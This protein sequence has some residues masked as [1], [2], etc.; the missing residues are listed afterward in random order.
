MSLIWAMQ[1]GPHRMRA[2]REETPAFPLVLGAFLSVMRGALGGSAWVQASMGV[3]RSVPKR[4][5]VGEC[6][7]RLDVTL[8]SP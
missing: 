7:G 6:G 1:R 4:S 3:Q 5:V 8:T 2:C